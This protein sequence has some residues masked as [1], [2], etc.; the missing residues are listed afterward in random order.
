MSTHITLALDQLQQ[1]ARNGGA[2][3]LADY[4][5]DDVQLTQ[6][7]QRTPPSAPAV[8]T[9]RDALLALGEELECRG[10]AMLPFHFL[11]KLL[12]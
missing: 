6:V 1:A 3:G 5:T 7:D 8:N 12:Q 11:E 2:A 4:V 9:G 10:I